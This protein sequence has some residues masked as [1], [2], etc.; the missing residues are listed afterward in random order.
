MPKRARLIKK[1]DSMAFIKKKG[2]KNQQDKKKPKW[3]DVY[4][5]D[6]SNGFPSNSVS[7]NSFPS[8]SSYQPITGIGSPVDPNSSPRPYDSLMG[9]F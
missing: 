6:S 4:N 8:N 2:S 3:M 7:F 9:L 1:R 5:K